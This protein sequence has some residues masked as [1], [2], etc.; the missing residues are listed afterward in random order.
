[1]KDALV[2]QSDEVEWH[3]FPSVRIEGQ[4]PNWMPPGAATFSW[5][6]RHKGYKKEF[7]EAMKQLDKL[8]AKESTNGKPK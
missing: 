4:Y 8:I 5:Q 2:T 1:M 6:K 7:N 3:C